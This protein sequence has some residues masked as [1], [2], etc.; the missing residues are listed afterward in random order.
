MNILPGASLMYVNRFRI[1]R[2]ITKEAPGLFAKK[3]APGHSVPSVLGPA[4]AEDGWEYT[5]SRY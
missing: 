3:K 1:L 4:V 5:S 2:V